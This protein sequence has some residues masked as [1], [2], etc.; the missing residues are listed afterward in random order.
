[1]DTL[2]FWG[3]MK[4]NTYTFTKCLFFFS[5][6]QNWIVRWTRETVENHTNM[7]ED[8]Q[9]VSNDFPG[10]IRDDVGSKSRVILKLI[11]IVCIL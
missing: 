2:D 6:T 11:N 3:S 5:E 1:M 8:I 7:T 9:P 10:R 4:N